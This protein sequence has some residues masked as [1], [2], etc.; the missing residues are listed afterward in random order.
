MVF[1][2]PPV[3]GGNSLFSPGIEDTSPPIVTF[4]PSHVSSSLPSFHPLA[5]FLFL[6]PARRKGAQMIKYPQRSMVEPGP[7]TKF[8]NVGTPFG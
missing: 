1:R 8:V 2:A 5:L 7:G 6:S 4:P 3:T